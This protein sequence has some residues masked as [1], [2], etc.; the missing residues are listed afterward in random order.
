MKYLAWLVAAFMIAAGAAGIVAPDTILR[1]RSLAARQGALLVFAALRITLGVVFIMTAP[2]SRTPR[3]LQAA[4]AVLLLA[5]LATP[6]FGVERTRAVLAWEAAQGPWLIRLGGAIVV[7][8]GGLLTVALTP[9]R[10]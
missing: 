8:L 9:R 2:A 6:L 1:L 5:G 7:A 3:T 4:G 10:T